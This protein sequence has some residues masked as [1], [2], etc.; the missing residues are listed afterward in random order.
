MQWA[1]KQCLL[2]ISVKVMFNSNFKSLFKFTEE[3]FSIDEH[4]NGSDVNPENLFLKTRISKGLVSDRWF[5]LLSNKSGEMKYNLVTQSAGD[6]IFLLLIGL[7]IVILC[8]FLCNNMYKYNEVKYILTSF[9]WTH[10]TFLK[11]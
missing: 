11:L 1:V 5:G 10:S 3:Y 8:K 7:L 9:R 6:C 4:F 2:L